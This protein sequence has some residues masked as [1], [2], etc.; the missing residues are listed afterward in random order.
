[1]L[2]IKDFNDIKEASEF[3]IKVKELDIDKLKEAVDT[4]KESWLN[5]LL[6]NKILP[7]ELYSLFK[8]REDKKLLCDFFI[9]KDF[10]PS[11]EFISELQSDIEMDDI[12]SRLIRKFS[13]IP[14]DY[15]QILKMINE[16]SMNSAVELVKNK[17][18][19]FKKEIII[20][21][22]KNN[23]KDRDLLKR[24]YSED[25]EFLEDILLETMNLFNNIGVSSFNNHLI[26][27]YIDV[28]NS[29]DVTEMHNWFLE[30]M[31]R[32]ISLNAIERLI[33]NAPRETVSRWSG[34]RHA[35]GPGHSIEYH[36]KFEAY[37]TE[38]FDNVKI[39]NTPL[40]S[41]FRE[42]YIIDKPQSHDIGADEYIIM[43]NKIKNKEIY[44]NDS[45]KKRMYSR[46]A[47]CSSLEQFKSIDLK[48]YCELMSPSEFTESTTDVE[49]ALAFFEVADYKHQKRLREKVIPPERIPKKFN[50][51]KKSYFT[52]VFESLN[53]DISLFRDYTRNYGYTL[54]KFVEDTF[55]SSKSR[56]CETKYVNHEFLMQ[57]DKDEFL[58]MIKSNLR[59]SLNI[60]EGVENTFK[61]YFSV[62]ET[63]SVYKRFDRIE[64]MFACEESG[65]I[66]FLKR[67]GA[68]KY[69]LSNLFDENKE[70]FLNNKDYADAYAEMVSNLDDFELDEELIS[71]LSPYF[72]K[73]GFR[74]ILNINSYY[75]SDYILL[76]DKHGE[77]IIDDE[78]ILDRF[79]N[80]RVIESQSFLENLIK[81]NNEMAQSLIK[82]YLGGNKELS[83]LTGK[84]VKIRRSEK[85]LF[86]KYAK[87]MDQ[88]ADSIVQDL[89]DNGAVYE[90]F[91]E[92]FP[93]YEEI[94]SSLDKGTRIFIKKTS[95]TELEH[96]CE[97]NSHLKFIIEYCDEAKGYYW[98]IDEDSNIYFE[99]VK[100][101]QLNIDRLLK[102][103][104]INI[105][106]KIKEYYDLDKDSIIL[107]DEL[108]LDICKKVQGTFLEEI[109]DVRNFLI[110]YLNNSENQSEIVSYMSDDEEV[111]DWLLDKGLMMSEELVLKL[112]KNNIKKLSYLKWI[113]TKIGKIDGY[114]ISKEK[115]KDYFSDE[116]DEE[117]LKFLKDR[118]FNI[119]TKQDYK[120]YALKNLLKEE[121]VNF[122]SK[123]ISKLTLGQ[124][125]ELIEFIENEIDD[126]YKELQLKSF[127]IDTLDTIQ[128]YATMQTMV[129]LDEKDIINILNVPN[130]IKNNKKIIK[131][132]ID[133]LTVNS[134]NI[135]YKI[136]LLKQAFEIVQ[137]KDVLVLSDFLDY[138]N[139]KEVKESESFEQIKIETLEFFEKYRNEIQQQEIF[140]YKKN[141]KQVLRFIRSGQDVTIV[142][143]TFEMISEISKGRIKQLDLV[144][145][146]Q[147]EEGTEDRVNK[148]RESIQVLTDRLSEVTAMDHVDHMHDRLIPLMK[149]IQEDPT[150]PIGQDKFI[151]LEKRDLES[152]V[153]YNLYFP[154]TR[155]DVQYLGETYGWCVTGAC[156]YTR[157][158]IKNGNILVSAVEKGQEVCKENVIALAHY[159][160]NSNGTYRLEQFRW[161]KQKKGGRTNISATDHF[162][163]SAIISRIEQYLVESKEKR[164]KNDE[165]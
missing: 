14:F 66:E 51:R 3:R 22:L 81:R 99:N 105:I 93:N 75:F 83:K 103:E 7:N 47:N 13:S 160:K 30:L 90:E 165:S 73:K 49:K 27:A 100:I 62:E 76:K 8:S 60:S 110:N 44:V 11:R 31:D 147:N 40:E 153:G 69:A 106:Q 120:L 129:S 111:S 156:G 32:D 15:K 77:Y 108:S 55:Q 71:F 74:K 16:G 91:Q 41:K 37:P 89:L 130:N 24:V 142:R 138:S 65:R 54:D 33:F 150:Q 4:D 107:E 18:D 148:L 155:G 98:G 163:Y 131:G 63:L 145:Q 52:E 151:G 133:V 154:K 97:R 35:D 127:N 42:K 34:R 115:I 57:L 82:A 94:L 6:E 126:R 132:I 9:E 104:N 101:K 84:E 114:T 28:A 19:F 112:I 162:K 70:L 88:G 48:E 102:K 50:K 113:E 58:K 59:L 21:L 20:L 139:P 61:Y 53:K 152:E 161:A 17:R 2:N 164:K 5:L 67:T 125:V 36:K 123:D 29:S 72:D 26:S 25:N 121:G 118:N 116:I 159:I 144:V 136:Y 64:L 38:W 124:K 135:L 157:G 46:F 128:N 134:G 85:K 143:D 109:L 117:L 137:C 68:D 43:I 141:K 96:I 1:M 10:L 56:M 87:V 39:E 79:D 146:L 45:K 80:K 149:F 12:L 78:E 95:L 86:E 140:L 23:L 119:L 92:K 122:T 158:V